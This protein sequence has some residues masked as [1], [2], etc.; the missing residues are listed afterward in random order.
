MPFLSSQHNV[1]LEKSEIGSSAGLPSGGG[2]GPTPAHDDPGTGA[3]APESAVTTP[4]ALARTSAETGKKSESGDRKAFRH[5][6]TRH[7]V[8]SRHLLVTVAVIS[9]KR[10][11]RRYGLFVFSRSLIENHFCLWTKL[12]R[13]KKK[14]CFLLQVLCLYNCLCFCSVCSTT[15]WVGQLDKRTQ[16]QDVACLLE[17]FGQIE[18]INVSE[19][20]WR[21]SSLS[22]IAQ[23]SSVI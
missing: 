5:P 4:P 19:L 9:G 10:L 14:K 16:Q 23:I 18:S 21:T 13:F 8:V 20:S 6:K 2:R 15:L 17:E 11:S 7:S 12:V 1:Y 22:L 3:R